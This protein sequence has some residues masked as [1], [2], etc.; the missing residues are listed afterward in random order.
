MFSHETIF[1]LW[2]KQ[3]HIP[4]P[5]SKKNYR[6]S[7]GE[8]EMWGIFCETPLVDFCTHSKGHGFLVKDM[9]VDNVSFRPSKTIFYGRFSASL[10]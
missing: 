6:V 1:A 9:G 5:S 8:G 7:K 4:I 2:V 10:P 3:G